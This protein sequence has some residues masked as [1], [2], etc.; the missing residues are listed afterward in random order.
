[1]NVDLRVPP[2]STKTFRWQLNGSHPVLRDHFPSN[3]LVPA[4]MQL[5]AVRQLVCTWSE[6]S[7]EEIRFRNV[8]FM[9]PLLPDRDAEIVVRRVANSSTLAFSLSVD[10][11]ILTRGEIAAA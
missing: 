11:E 2:D 8:K 6:V 7:A 3:P 10:G 5:E 4:F 9:V 1:M